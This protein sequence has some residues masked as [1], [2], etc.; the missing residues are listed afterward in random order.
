M[1]GIND[2]VNWIGDIKMKKYMKKKKSKLIIREEIYLI[3]FHDY[4][5]RRL[6]VFKKTCSACPCQY[7]IYDRWPKK[8]SDKPKYYGRLRWGYF[9]VAKKPLGKPIYEFKFEDD[10][11][12]FYTIPLEIEHL[13]KACE[14]IWKKKN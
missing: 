7:D 5:K 14:K 1:Y 12:A 11:G 2:L 8:D 9:Y 4:V 6:L 13:K 10:K 3:T